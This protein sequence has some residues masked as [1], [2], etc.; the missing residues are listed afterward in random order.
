[1]RVPRFSTS[2][3][4]YLLLIGAMIAG[5]WSHPASTYAQS[6]GEQEFA[7]TPANNAKLAFKAAAEAVD[8][9]DLEEARDKFLEAEELF[10]KAEDPELAEKAHSNAIRIQY[11]LGRQQLQQGNLDAA[12]A[13]YERGIEFAP[14]FANNY[15]MKAYA[16]KQQGNAEEAI[17]W[18]Q[19]AI[20]VAQEQENT[21]IVNKAN[22][23]IAGIWLSR[24]GSAF[25]EDNYQ[26]GIEHI[27]RATEFIEMDASMYYQYARGNNGLQNYEQALEYANQGLEVVNQNNMQDVSNLYFQKGLA[28]K[29]LGRTEESC[30]VMG[31]V[32]AGPYQQNAKYEMK[33]NLDC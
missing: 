30:E 27:D 13:A 26:T 14:D 20:D 21:A 31:Q 19:N 3:F 29:N 22:N 7:D 11:N 23:N 25:D 24:A 15:F 18:Y 8:N 16:L 28:L 1:M 10:R 5:A 32:S 6:S 2:P 17:T 4:V 9:D 33:H 12:I